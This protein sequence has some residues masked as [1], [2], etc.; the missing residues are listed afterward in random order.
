VIDPTRRLRRLPSPRRTSR[1]RLAS[2]PARAAAQEVLLA[3]DAGAAVPV[4]LATPI[5]SLVTRHL[6]RD[7][8]LILLVV[9]PSV[10]FVAL[11]SLRF[12]ALMLILAIAATLSTHGYAH[13]YVEAT[14]FCI[15]G[16]LLF[17]TLN[18]IGL[19]YVLTDQRVLR[20]SGL[21]NPEIYD[22][23]LRK[24]ARTRVL[25]TFREKLTGLGTIEIIPQEE[26]RPCGLWSMIA[27]PIEINARLS[28]TIRRAKAG[29]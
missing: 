5:A 17:A 27:K 21:L 2:L 3:G 4:P 25:R 7:G 29:A 22:C 8:E 16:R 24:V 15:A 10:W 11:S 14:V 1:R 18:W 6:L 9:K 20:I 23:P 13:L 19:L 28:E 12:I 26:E